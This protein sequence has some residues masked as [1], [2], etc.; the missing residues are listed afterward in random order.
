M[1]NCFQFCLNFAINFNSRP[2]IEVT[3]EPV[4]PAADTTV[5]R[6]KT[7]TTTV[8]RCRL[9]HGIAPPHFLPDGIGA[10]EVVPNISS[11][12]SASS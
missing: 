8:G 9:K 1:L 6:T 7:V 5:L 3:R 2:Y 12:P 11:P 10:V 4:P